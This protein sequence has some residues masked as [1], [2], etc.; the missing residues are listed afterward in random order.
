M[1]IGVG[2][3]EGLD[4]V[5]WDLSGILRAKQGE[6]QLPGLHPNGGEMACL[7]VHFLWVSAL[8]PCLVLL[9]I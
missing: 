1:G 2:E 5:Q 6:N 8:S 9:G 3:G 4:R 7:E